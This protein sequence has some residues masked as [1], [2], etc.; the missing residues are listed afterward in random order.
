[1]KILFL[2]ALLTTALT[3]WAEELPS[4]ASEYY[5]MNGTSTDNEIQ[6]EEAPPDIGEVDHFYLDKVHTKVIEPSRIERTQNQMKDNP[7]NA[8]FAASFGSVGSSTK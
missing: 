4:S 7:R 3:C 1:M 6:K 8:G 2:F 5:L